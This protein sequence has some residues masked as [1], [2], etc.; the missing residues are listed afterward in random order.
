M[1]A[2]SFLELM[3]EHWHLALH[4]RHMQII[5]HAERCSGVLECYEVCPVDCWK[6]DPLTGTVEFQNEEACIAC[7]ACVLQC[8]EEA[9]ELR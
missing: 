5:F 9:I 3:K 6:P 7:G 4:L 2:P 1:Q 8:P